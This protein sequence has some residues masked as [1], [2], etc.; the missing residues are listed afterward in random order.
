MIRDYPLVVRIKSDNEQKNIIW[1]D[2]V[3]VKALRE[4]VENNKRNIKE[5]KYNRILAE[6]ISGNKEAVDFI[7]IWNSKNIKKAWAEHLN[8]P[9]LYKKGYLDT[10]GN[11]SKLGKNTWI[12]DSKSEAS[13]HASD[14]Y[15]WGCLADIAEIVS[16]NMQFIE[17]T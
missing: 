1:N 13:N 7:K 17:K 3:I 16:L 4:A 9:Y 14:C 6:S 15:F 5:E 12:F 2:P 11:F 8:F 10:R